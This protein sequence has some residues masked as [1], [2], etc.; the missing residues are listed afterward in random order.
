MC[1]GPEVSHLFTCPMAQLCI[2]VTGC[3]DKGTLVGRCNSKIQVSVSLLRLATF[4]YRP[5]AQELLSHTGTPHFRKAMP[6][7][8]F[9]G[10]TFRPPASY[11]FVCFLAIG[12]GVDVTKLCLSALDQSNVYPSLT[13]IWSGQLGPLSKASFLNTLTVLKRATQLCALACPSG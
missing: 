2:G 10:L 9:C 11:V 5:A 3:L 13:F 4:A 1:P 7:R 6:S 8:L 12:I